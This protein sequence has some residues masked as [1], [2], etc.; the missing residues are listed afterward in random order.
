MEDSQQTRWRTAT[1][2]LNVSDPLV[3]WLVYRGEIVSCA[4]AHERSLS[5]WFTRYLAA[6]AS[7]QRRR[8]VFRQELILEEL[9]AQ[10]YPD[11]VS[12]LTG[13]YVFADEPSAQA[14]NQR[15]G[16]LRPDFLVEVALRPGS[17][18]SRHDA[19]WITHYLGDAGARDWM[20]AYLRG[21]Q[22]GSD[23]IW[24]LLVDGRALVLG[25][26]L[27]EAAY[28]TVKAKWPTSLPLLELSRVAA[29]LDSDLG[30]ISA[31]SR[32]DGDHISVD[33]AVNFVDATN[34]AFLTRL[35]NFEG[36]KDTEDL[37]PQSGL[38]VP[39]L[40]DRGLELGRWASSR[41]RGL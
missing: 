25:T 30:L 1:V 14:A 3:A 12:R 22:S 33:Y 9:R 29:D 18:T 37:G 15:W 19:E 32:V 5:F 23:P 11:A 40:R 10:Q 36:P 26:E 17:R 16:F 28:E 27:R 34:P 4:Q 31:I 20:S 7:A 38:I 35:E 8:Q 24:E 13:F 21:D 6:E 39:D 41:V 2:Y